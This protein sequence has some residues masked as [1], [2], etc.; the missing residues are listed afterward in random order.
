[1]AGPVTKLRWGKF[2]VLASILVAVCVMAGGAQ[3]ANVAGCPDADQDGV[4]DSADNCV[5]ISNPDQRDSD[6]D[7]FGNACDPDLNNDGVVNFTDLAMIKSVFF[8]SA[9]AA[10]AA[11]NADLN[12]D[13]VVNFVDLAIMK[14]FF[15]KAPGPSNALGP[16]TVLLTQ[17]AHGAFIL[18]TG[19]ACQIPVQGSVPNAADT[20][21]SLLVNGT[22]EVTSNGQFQTSLNAAPIFAPVLAEATR[23][24]VHGGAPDA[25]PSGQMTRVQNVALCGDSIAENDLALRSVGVRVNNSGFMK[26]MPLI[27]L[28]VAGQ[29]P[30]IE[31][32][33]QAKSPIHVQQ[34]FGGEVYGVCVGV[35]VGDITIQSVNLGS[36]SLSL[37]SVTN[38]LQI[39]GAAAPVDLA[40]HVD[41][42]GGCDGHVQADSLD[43]SALLGLQPGTPRSQLD[44]NLN[45]TPTVT[46]RNL[47]NNFTGGVCDFLFLPDLINTFVNPALQNDA[48]GALAKALDNSGS[49]KSILATQLQ[50]ALSG[51]SIAG[52]VGASLGLTLQALFDTISE[53]NV[54]VTFPLDANVTPPAPGPDP[55][56][57]SYKM[58]DTF[59]SFGATEPGGQV[60]D[61]AL[62]ISE[63]LLNKLLRSDAEE[64]KFDAD[65]TTFD[66]GGGPQTLST[67]LLGLLVPGFAAVSPPENLVVR[68]R[69]TLAPV[70]TVGS[71]STNARVE[72]A[73]VDVTVVGKVSGKTYLTTRLNGRFEVVPSVM[74]N[75][76]NFTVP[77]GGVDSANVVLISSTIGVTDA[78]ITLLNALLAAQLNKSMIFQTLDSVQLPSF[79]GLTLAPVAVQQDAGFINLFVNLTL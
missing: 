71:A 45:A 53:D 62:S 14:N 8:Q 42:L 49:Q 79:Q 15:F 24:R 66:F 35:F 59:P 44:V 41:V 28:A 5:N 12:G 37:G 27:D 1:M 56:P 34:C 18:P 9:S 69:P 36:V 7:G 51:L 40:Y 39:N 64:R 3:N 76:I 25:G 16:P 4:C 70:L 60:Y 31:Q 72:I 33:I 77:P 26:L 48:P 68:F 38:A 61:V 57:A 20:V 67:G 10:A 74:G 6:G 22:P 50:N 65:L 30:A 23:E 75:S 43:I 19:S 47:R 21:L 55:L 78:Q 11:A 58:N 46:A 73:G 2:A 63:N 29:I 32:A 54:G 52:T 13:G 17:P